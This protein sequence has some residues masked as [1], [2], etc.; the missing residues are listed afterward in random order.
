MSE[1]GRNVE[2]WEYSL[3]PCST[4]SM[5]V[6]VRTTPPFAIIC[7]KGKEKEF[8]FPDRNLIPHVLPCM[9]YACFIELRLAITSPKRS[10]TF[11]RNTDNKSK[12]WCL[13][14]FI[15]PCPTEG[16][17]LWMSQWSGFPSHQIIEHEL[18]QLLQDPSIQN[19]MCLDCL[20]LTAG[21]FPRHG[22]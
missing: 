7:K 11:N 17:C 10:R 8:D 20:G 16:F 15:I 4:G 22:L 12:S 6:P 18:L 2:L 13:K 5:C 9:C 1:G 3:S 14:N 21:Q 19:I